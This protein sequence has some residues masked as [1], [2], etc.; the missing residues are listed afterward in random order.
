MPRKSK[1]KGD[2]N[3]PQV[4]LTLP[5]GLIR[6]LDEHAAN[7]RRSRS[8]AAALL[9]ERALDAAQKAAS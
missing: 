6:R 5:A 8:N 9:I 3:S 2:V 1:S 4:T 7:E